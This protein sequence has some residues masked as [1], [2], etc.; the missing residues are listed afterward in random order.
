[1]TE[2]MPKTCTYHCRGWPFRGC[3]SH[4]SS[5]QAFDMHRQGPYDSERVCKDPAEAG[6]EPWTHTGRCDHARPK[7]RRA[8][9]IWRVVMSEKQRQGLARAVAK[10]VEPQTPREGQG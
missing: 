2:S 1:M 3:N 8:V 4:F 9:T 10:R 7:S 6:L 5:L